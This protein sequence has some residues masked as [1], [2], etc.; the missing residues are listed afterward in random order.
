MRRFSKRI[1]FVRHGQALHNVNAERMRAEGCSY[2]EFIAQMQ[3]DD[4]FDADL[5]SKGRADADA[6]SASCRDVQ[7]TIELVVASPL[8]RALETADRV[9]PD[10]S[11]PNARGNRVCLETIREINGLLLNGK[12]REKQE[13]VR[14]FPCWN[15]DA[16]ATEEDGTWKP[17]ALEDEQSVLDRAHDTLAW[18]WNRPERSIALVGH[19]GIF[20]L[21]LNDHPAI[22]VSP[23]TMRRFAN[24][25]VR[26]A[27]MTREETPI[28]VLNFD[29]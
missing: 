27:T 29:Q 26:S 4:A 19:G 18:I 13:L 15:F 3:A 2:E 28:F 9:F 10:S 8:S 20:G 25:E 1:H 11:L 24:C 17:D 16:I 23:S 12:R 5:T 22:K 6:C 7:K 21:M 14:K